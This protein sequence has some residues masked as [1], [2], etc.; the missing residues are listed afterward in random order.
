MIKRECSNMNHLKEIKRNITQPSFLYSFLQTRFFL[1]LFLCIL[2]GKEKLQICFWIN[3]VW[4]SL[5]HYTLSNRLA[6][7]SHEVI[8]SEIF[9]MVCTEQ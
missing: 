4:N 1:L 7:L 2:F 5:L 6:I 8:T 3:L 9:Q